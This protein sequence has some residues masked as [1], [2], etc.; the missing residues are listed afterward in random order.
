[1][2]AKA[3]VEQLIRIVG[4]DSVLDSPEELVAYSYDGTFEEHRPDVV[5]IPRTTGAGMPGGG[6]R[7]KRASPNRDSR[8]GLGTRRGF[9][10]L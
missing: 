10:S 7:C 5:V 4:K 3:A 1:M 9:D 8:H 2:L 6:I